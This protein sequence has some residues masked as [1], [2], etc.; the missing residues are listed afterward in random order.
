MKIKSIFGPRTAAHERPPEPAAEHSGRIVA[1]KVKVKKCKSVKV[2]K[3]KSVKVKKEIQ[4]END[5]AEREHG[6]PGHIIILDKRKLVV[7]FWGDF[8]TSRVVK[9]QELA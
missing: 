8:F 2:Q 5:A 9:R 7:K 6:S 4:N 1:L 3:C